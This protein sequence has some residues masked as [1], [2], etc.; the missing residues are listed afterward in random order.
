MSAVFESDIGLLQ[1]SAALHVDRVVGI[2][3]DVV[4]RGILQ[5]RLQRPQPKDF[6]QHFIG[7]ALALAGAERHSL[8]AHQRQ[9][10][11]QQRLPRPRVLHEQQ[12]LQVYLLDQLAMDGRLHFLLRP[13]QHGLG[14][15]IKQTAHPT[16][17]CR[18]RYCG[19]ISQDSSALQL[20]G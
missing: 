19:H 6:V 12:L 11:G 4:H 7:N 5:Q 15:V 8:F 14:S 18:Q 10:D 1:N 13:S 2:D 9:D 17:T 3:Q 16:C 20:K